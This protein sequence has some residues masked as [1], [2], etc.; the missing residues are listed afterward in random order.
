MEG[1]TMPRLC[2]LIY[3]N[4]LVSE[5][6]GTS[7]FMDFVQDKRQMAVLFENFVRTFYRVHTDFRV[8][9]AQ[10]RRDSS[11]RSLRK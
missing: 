3:R 10:K 2:E 5:K 1:A 8:R 6:P 11:A 4:L 9:R 7:K